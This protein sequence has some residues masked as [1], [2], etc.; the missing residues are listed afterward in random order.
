MLVRLG[1][2]GVTEVCLSRPDKMNVL[3]SAMFE[4]LRQAGEQLAREA[5]LRAVVLHGAGRAFCAGLDMGS[6]G[7]MAE[8]APPGECLADLFERSHGLANRAQQVAW[9]WR[10]LPVLLVAAVH[11][12]ALAVACKWRWVL[13]CAT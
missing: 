6:F 7:R 5:E 9:Q 2:D 12:V 3:D 13:T 4:G 8:G 1:A 11:G 10:E